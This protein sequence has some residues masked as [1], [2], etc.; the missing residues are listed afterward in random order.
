MQS[1]PD[2]RR[3]N[4]YVA[5]KLRSFGRIVELTASGTGQNPENAAQTGPERQ[6]P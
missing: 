1:Q 5:P 3:D 2:S 6:R 4:E